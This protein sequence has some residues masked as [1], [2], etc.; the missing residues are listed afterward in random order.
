MN[1]RPFR[2]K[3]V[4]ENGKKRTLYFGDMYIAERCME[5]LGEKGIESELYWKTNSGVLRQ[6]GSAAEL[7][8]I[9]SAARKFFDGSDES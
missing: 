2:V 6:V 1:E 4:D 7:R 8:E 3:Y 9:R 5:T